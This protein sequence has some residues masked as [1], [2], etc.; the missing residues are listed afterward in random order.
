MLFLSFSR[1]I[2]K[3]LATALW[4]AC[5]LDD[6]SPPPPPPRVVPPSDFLSLVGHSARATQREDLTVHIDSAFV[7]GTVTVFAVGQFVPRTPP[8]NVYTDC[9]QYFRWTVLHVFGIRSPCVG[10]FASTGECG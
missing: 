2:A 4:V 10:K 6:L 1:R 5:G 3:P 7:P 9:V 8:R